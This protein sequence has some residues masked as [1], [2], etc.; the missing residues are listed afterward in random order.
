MIV[1]SWKAV[2]IGAFIMISIP[3][4]LLG[5]WLGLVVVCLFKT[6]LALTKVLPTHI[7]IN[8]AL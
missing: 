4:A 5:G 6:C 2:R 1:F 3:L 7:H 8:T